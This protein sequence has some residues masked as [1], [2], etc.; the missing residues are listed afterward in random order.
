MPGPGGSVIHH[1]VRALW[2]LFVV[3]EKKDETT[4]YLC[5]IVPSY[6]QLPS[7]LIRSDGKDHLSDHLTL[8]VSSFYCFD[9]LYLDETDND[10]S[11]IM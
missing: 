4:S 6:F 10:I 3:I 9:T 2:W 1:V 8:S 5:C 11:I 7:G